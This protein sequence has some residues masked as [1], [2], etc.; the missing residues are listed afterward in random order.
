MCW[1]IDVAFSFHPAL[2]GPR[3]LCHGSSSTPALHSSYLPLA[4]SGRILPTLP[5]LTLQCFYPADFYSQCDRQDDVPVQIRLRQTILRALGH[6]PHVGHGTVHGGLAHL[7][8]SNTFSNPHQH[9]FP[10]SGNFAAVEWNTQALFA[11]DPQ[12]FRDNSAYVH[13]LM[14]S[15]DIGLWT[16]THGTITGNKAWRNPHGCTS[17]WAPGPSPGVAGVGI[18]VRNDFLRRFEPEPKFS[19][20]MP[21]RAAVLR[22]RGSQQGNLDIFVMYFQTGSEVKDHDIH[23]AGLEHLGHTPS[24]V[25]LRDALRRRLARHIAPRSATLSFLGGDFNYVADPDD[26]RAT[27]SMEASGRRD[28]QEQ[29]RWK[30]WIEAPYGI[31]ELHQPNMTYASPN[32]RSRLDRFY[33]NQD[34]T[35]GLDRHMVCA[36]MAWRP[37]LS[38]HRPIS[39]RRSVPQH[40]KEKDRPIPDH[41]LDDKRWPSKVALAHGDLLREKPSAS[42]LRSL[43]LL[44]K[45]M[46]TAACNMDNMTSGEADALSLEDRVGVAMRFVRASERGSAEAVSTCITR[47]PLLKELVSNPYDFSSP[48]HDRLRLAKQHAI[49]LA[50]DH[51]MQEL[52]RLQ[53]DLSELTDVQVQQRRRRNHRLLSKLSPGKG[54]SSFALADEHGQNLLRP[55]DDCLYAPWALAPCFPPQADRR[56]PPPEL[57]G[58]RKEMPPSGL[59][60]PYTE[61]SSQPQNL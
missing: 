25:E 35:D 34:A 10:Y 54:C 30:Q 41:V 17:W 39:F 44:K 5:P 20:I 19:I 32:S 8:R 22:M 38:R 28:A 14:A 7:V 31:H 46:R 26:R 2:A 47:Y 21:G 51:A 15:H 55:R 3:V 57:A 40:K 33:C 13:K 9:S 36:A 4:P 60:Q 16:E 24:F 37:E 12:K 43:I 53:E 56:Q 49:E 61:C 29:T 42:L 50:R 27:D 52:G 48:V 18:T 1:I 6:T 11:C 23:D 59:P 45:A 58:R